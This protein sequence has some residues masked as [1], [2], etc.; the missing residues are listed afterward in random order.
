MN[1]GKNSQ[2]VQFTPLSLTAAAAGS[3]DIR[4]YLLSR[5]FMATEYR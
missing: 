1:N 5:N 2:K 4:G 3:R